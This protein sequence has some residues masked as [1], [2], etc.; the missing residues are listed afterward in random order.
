MAVKRVKAQTNT[1]TTGTILDTIVEHKRRELERHL[2]EMPA[3]ELEARIKQMPMPLNFSGALLG[4]RVRLIAE[5]KKAS[6]SRGLLVP[7]FD[8]VALATCYADNGAAAI[9]VLTEVDHFQG[10]LDDLRNV[11]EVVSGKRLP[12]LRK[13][14][15]FDPYQLYEARAYGADAVLLIVAM[16][17]P[18]QLTELLA[19]AQSLWLQAL[20]EV[21]SR[22]EL[23][24][25][26]EAGAEIIGVNHRDLKTF[27]MDMSLSAQLRPLVPQ[28]KLVVAESG[29]SKADDVR[30]LKEAGVHAVLVGEALVTAS[31]TAAKVKELAGS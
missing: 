12:V 25:A 26:L 6:P 4:D 27:K 30:R 16:L 9:S 18:A 10:S 28:G 15:L 20:V 23:E 17:S 14:F 1:M 7:H 19:V 13:D 21:H 24:T 3:A 22:R 31:D 2:R 8:P 29:I 5:V 11:R